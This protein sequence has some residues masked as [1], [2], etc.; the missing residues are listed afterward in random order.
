ML[1][2]AQWRPG[3]RNCVTA[4]WNDNQICGNCHP[5]SGRPRKRT[6]LHVIGMIHKLMVYIWS[7]RTSTSYTTLVSVCFHHQACKPYVRRIFPDYQNEIFL[8]EQITKRSEQFLQKY[9]ERSFKRLRITER[10]F[11]FV[12]NCNKLRSSENKQF[13]F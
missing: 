7:P 5:R 12:R 1:S 6:A 11:I 9:C 4:I 10:T 2:P 8:F 3:K 13:L